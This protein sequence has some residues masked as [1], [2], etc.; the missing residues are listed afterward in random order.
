[1][2]SENHMWHRLP[3]KNIFIIVIILSV[4]H[5]FESV[6]TKLIEKKPT[7]LKAIAKQFLRVWILINPNYIIIHV[8]FRTGAVYLCG[9]LHTL[10]EV[11][12]KMHAVHVDGHL[13]LELGDWLDTRK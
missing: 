5:W 12:P 6:T 13:E 2:Y 10:A 4:T 7:S 1:M 9:H 11:V 8:Y 3:V